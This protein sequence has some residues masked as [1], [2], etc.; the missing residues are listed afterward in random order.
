[1]AL[2]TNYAQLSQI[3]DPAALLNA[4]ERVQKKNASGGSDRQ[5]VADFAD[6]QARELNALRQ[7]LLTETY[8]PRPLQE[9][10]VPKPGKAGERRTL[11][12]PSVRDKVAQESVRHVIGPLLERHFLPH[13]FGYRHGFGPQKAIECVSTYIEKEETN[14]VV[15]IDIDEFFPSMDHTLLMD[16]LR[17]FGIEEP[18][19]RLLLL[20]LKMGRVHPNGAWL[21]VYQGIAQ[22]CIVSPLLANLYLHSLDVYLEEQKVPWARYADDIRMFSETRQQAET[23]F[24]HVSDLLKTK[25]ALRLNC[26]PSTITAVGDGFTFLGIHF[27][28]GERKI[29]PARWSLFEDKMR[30]V[31]R[32]HCSVDWRSAIRSLNESVAGWKRYYG[33]LVLASEMQRLE[34]LIQ[35]VLTD[36][37]IRQAPANANGLSKGFQDAL[38]TLE[39]PCAN[40]EGERKQFIAATCAKIRDGCKRHTATSTQTERRVERVV[41][42]ERS[43]YGRQTMHLSHLVVTSP[44][45]FVGKSDNQLVVRQNGKVLYSV[46]LL[47]LKSV[48]LAC[49]G[50]SISSDIISHCAREGVS[51]CWLGRNGQMEV[52]LQ[53]ASMPSTELQIRQV[54][55]A[56]EPL[57]GFEL[58]RTIVHGKLKNQLH[59]I[60]YFCKYAKTASG[61]QVAHQYNLF[62]D[63]AKKLLEELKGLTS[64]KDWPQLRGHVFSIEGRFASLYWDMFQSL[65]KDKVDFPGRTHQGATDLTNQL[66]NYGYAILQARVTQDI[67]RHGLNPYIGVLHSVRGKQASLAFDIM[68]LFR[69]QAVDRIVLS[70]LRRKSPHY[71]LD[72][73]GRLSEPTRRAITRKIYARFESIETFQGNEMK[74]EE[75]M[76][77][78]I[79]D[80]GR[81]LLGKGVFN[82]YVATW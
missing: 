5:S 65:L 79:E 60:K 2:K 81:C 47:N 78:Q 4:W 15:S 20:W 19:C 41:R 55:I 76:R 13:S 70:E 82:A 16:Q 53:S 7:E 3:A 33:N 29:D 31:L 25:L 12:L 18:V 10:Q 1:M 44:G 69:P 48:T 62:T 40:C 23:L 49:E 54:E 77:K 37:Y 67:F 43:R 17:S 38:Q 21:D 14:W 71:Y 39:L 32:K 22:G 80:F 9:F 30:H 50:N 6:H 63:A 72:D 52:L 26:N 56:Q 58:A 46:S 42:R 28:D 74:M 68:E 66:L 51:L 64:T 27:A 45:L 24:A 57:K 73:A 36:H 75:I 59:L 61:Q 34:T 8:V 35:Q 11:V